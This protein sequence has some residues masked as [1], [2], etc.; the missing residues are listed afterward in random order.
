MRP[1]LVKERGEI[2]FNI[3]ESDYFHIEKHMA[4]IVMEEKFSNCAELEALL[5]QDSC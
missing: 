5:D 3:L 2:G 4:G 1:L